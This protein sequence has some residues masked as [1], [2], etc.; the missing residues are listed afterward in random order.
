MIEKKYRQR[1]TTLLTLLRY[2]I[3]SEN[4]TTKGIIALKRTATS[5][6]EGK[7]AEQKN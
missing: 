4:K 6:T 7:T 3:L 2:L 1:K 5:A